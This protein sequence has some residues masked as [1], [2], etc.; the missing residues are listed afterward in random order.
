MKTLVGALGTA[1]TSKHSDR[2]FIL[3]LEW[4]NACCEWERAGN[5]FGTDPLHFLTP[6]LGVRKCY[7]R[8]VETTEC[9]GCGLHWNL[10][11]SD[12]IGCLS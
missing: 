6:I 1:F 9:F 7:S 11:A 5:V 8:H 12:R 10:F 2:N 3:A 4:K